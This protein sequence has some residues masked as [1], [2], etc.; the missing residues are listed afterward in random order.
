MSDD[1]SRLAWQ[2]EIAFQSLKNLTN[3]ARAACAL[4]K[5]LLLGPYE[6]LLGEIRNDPVFQKFNLSEPRQQWVLGEALV[7]IHRYEQYRYRDLVVPCKDDEILDIGA[8][9]GE[10]AL[11]FSLFSPRKI[12]C[13]EVDPDNRAVLEQTIRR[14][15]IPCEI[16]AAAVGDED[17]TAWYSRN[18]GNAGGGTVHR[19]QRENA[20]AVKLVT[21]DSFVKELMAHPV[22]AYLAT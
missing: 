15:N 6:R 3:N 11:W 4:T 2:W 21:I 14:E 8:C 9:F 20:D 22:K 16:V 18:P 19:D 7:S 10:S 1:E 13:F 5:G 12:Y 17:G